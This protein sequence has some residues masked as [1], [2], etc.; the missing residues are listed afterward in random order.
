MSEYTKEPWGVEILGEDC[1]IFD[2]EG[3]VIET[4]YGL[5][6]VTNTQRIVVCVNACAGIE[7]DKL[8]RAGGLAE[9]NVRMRLL[10]AEMQ[11]CELLAALEAVLHS[12]DSYGLSLARA[13]IAKTKGES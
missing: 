11:C 6:S 8:E 4:F 3:K 2:A 12:K 1:L 7:T 9:I 13:A 5:N 10:A